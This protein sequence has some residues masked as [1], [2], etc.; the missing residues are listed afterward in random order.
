MLTAGPTPD[1]ETAE[2][3]FRIDGM[4]ADEAGWTWEEFHQLEFEQN[5]V[6]KRNAAADR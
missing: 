3:T 4:V 1:V 2:W 5:R 6:R